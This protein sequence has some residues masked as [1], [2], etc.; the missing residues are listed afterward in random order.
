MLGSLADA[1]EQGRLISEGH[2]ATPLTSVCS[3]CST[4]KDEDTVEA[5]DDGM[6][7]PRIA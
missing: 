7:S 5:V 6:S 3:A 4:C 2:A 1:V